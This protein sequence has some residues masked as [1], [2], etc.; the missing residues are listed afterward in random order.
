V[1]AK[2][3]DRP[4]K[5]RGI[6]TALTTSQRKAAINAM[7]KAVADI[8]RD[9]QALHAVVGGVVEAAD[10]IQEADAEIRAV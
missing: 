5:L 10:E 9:S 3:S 4:I 6:S 1:A 2:R 8:E 7:R